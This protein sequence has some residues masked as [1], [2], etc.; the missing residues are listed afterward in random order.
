MQCHVCVVCHWTDLARA[1]S[2]FNS[3]NNSGSHTIPTSLYIQVH[4]Y[5]DKSVKY[6]CGVHVYNYAH[7]Y[8]VHDICL[9]VYTG[10]HVT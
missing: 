3:G 1:S 8:Y 7:A 10:A 4:M 5:L 6:T 2:V 9:Q